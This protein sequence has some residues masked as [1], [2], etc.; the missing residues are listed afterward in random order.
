L[1]GL[2]VSRNISFNLLSPEVRASGG[3]F[4]Q[5]A[6]MPMPETAIDKDNSVVLG[7]LQIWV[8]G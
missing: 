5:M 7:K 2:S 4:E 3:P 6:V 8:A 1:N